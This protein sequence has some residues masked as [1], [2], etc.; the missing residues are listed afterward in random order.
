MAEAE[1]N[2]D[3]VPSG[4]RVLADGARVAVRVRAGRLEPRAIAA[5]LIAA[6]WGI[7]WITSLAG[8]LRDLGAG[9]LPNPAP[10]IAGRALFAA[11][12]VYC[13]LLCLWAMIGHERLVMRRGRLRLS[14]PWL[15][16]MLTRRY[17]L[18]H[19]RSFM[20]HD[21][22]CG[23]KH[24]GCCCHYSTV[25]YALAFDYSGRPVQLFPHLPRE[26]KDWLRDRLNKTLEQMRG[27][28]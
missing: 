21:K 27:N 6:L 4:V 10:E 18:A 25:D 11:T 8:A 7:L 20:T 9:K 15:L 26:S 14:N 16:G 5:M 12:G 17:D 1:L 13:V 22:D 2:A 3:A 19:V 23:A 28:G 24:D